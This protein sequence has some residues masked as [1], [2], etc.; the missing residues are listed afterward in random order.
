MREKNQDGLKNLISTLW[1]TQN[2]FARNGK[3]LHKNIRAWVIIAEEKRGAKA[4]GKRFGRHLAALQHF[5]FRPFHQFAQCHF[6]PR[7]VVA[8]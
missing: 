1:F 6:G 8:G 3:L 5:N 2:A 4:S 7:I